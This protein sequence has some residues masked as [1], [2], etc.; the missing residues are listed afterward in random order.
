M[1]V[2][3]RT[4]STLKDTV[5]ESVERGG[6]AHTVVG[7]VCE[8]GD[9]DGMVDE[10]AREFGGAGRA[11]QRRAV[12]GAAPLEQ[13]SYDDLE[14]TYRSGPLAT[15]H[16]MRAALPQL[17][18]SRGGVVNLGSS[19]AVRGESAFAAYAMAKEAIRGLSRMAA[20]EWSAY[21]IR[22]DVVCPA[23]QPGRGGAPRRPPRQGRTARRRH[24]PGEP[25]RPRGGHR[26]GCGGAGER[27]HGLSDGG[28]PD[29]GDGR[30][31][32]G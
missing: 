32:L 15:F 7:D 20:R 31:L 12:L 28:D 21:G 18:T 13:T 3:G 25:R 11:R 8:R 17:R 1:V 27:R 29:A 2:A 4:E 6:L 16:A 10:T 22:V 14:R 5:G 19:T 26:P 23:A 30:N 24:P 9:V